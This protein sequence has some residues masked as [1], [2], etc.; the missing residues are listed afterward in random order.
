LRATARAQLAWLLQLGETMPGA[1]RAGV[2]APECPRP[3]PNFGGRGSRK[4]IRF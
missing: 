3:A 2:K 1:A 4:T